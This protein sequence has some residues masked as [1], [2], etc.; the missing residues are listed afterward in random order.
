MTASVFNQP[1]AL[2]VAS[3]SGDADT[4]Y[5]QHVRQEL[6]RYTEAVAV[7][8]VLAHQQPT[9]KAWTDQVKAQARG[10]GSQLRHEH[11]EVALHSALQRDTASQLAPA[12]R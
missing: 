12:G 2:Q 6:M 8:A 7:G 10:G 4:A 11:V 3:G 1:A 9:G 5:A